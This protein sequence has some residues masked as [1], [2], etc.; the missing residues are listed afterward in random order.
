MH[1]RGGATENE[2]RTGAGEG[3]IATPQRR[4]GRPISFPASPQGR[5]GPHNAPVLDAAGQMFCAGFG[6]L[7][8]GRGQGSVWWERAVLPDRRA[9]PAGAAAGEAGRLLGGTVGI[10]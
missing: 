3:V 1:L 5:T 9:A 6:V 7:R 8:F 4:N 10:I 2:N